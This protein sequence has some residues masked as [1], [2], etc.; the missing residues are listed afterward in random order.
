MSENLFS[1]DIEIGQFAILKHIKNEPSYLSRTQLTEH[2]QVLSIRRLENH[3]K[4]LIV[5]PEPIAAL[6]SMIGCFC[7]PSNGT[8]SHGNEGRKETD[9]DMSSRCYKRV[10]EACQLCVLKTLLA[11]VIQCSGITGPELLPD[12]LLNKVTLKL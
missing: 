11:E 12:F 2:G 7:L 3:V 5:N 8:T 10:R 6:A 9:L 1:A 4:V